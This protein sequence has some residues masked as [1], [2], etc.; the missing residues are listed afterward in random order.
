MDKA[1]DTILD[2]KRRKVELIY[3]AEILKKC[4]KDNIRR[5][6]RNLSVEVEDL[7]KRAYVK[8]KAETLEDSLILSQ[9]SLIKG[10]KQA[11]YGVADGW[12]QASDLAQYFV[13][14]LN[15]IAKEEGDLP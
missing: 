11:G 10:I 14:R 4:E 1:N 12:F 13:K 3:M 6:G 5:I 7:I 15:E 2:K 8:I 9:R